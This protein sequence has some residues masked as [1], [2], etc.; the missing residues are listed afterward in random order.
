MRITLFG[1]LGAFVVVV[2]LGYVFYEWQQSSQ[3]NEQPNP[4]PN[5]PPNL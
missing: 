2:L 4:N 1:V 5:P 3:K